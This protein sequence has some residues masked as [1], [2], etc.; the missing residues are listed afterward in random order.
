MR[1]PGTHNKTFFAAK[2]YENGKNTE[3]KLTNSYLW[4][5]TFQRVCPRSPN[6]QNIPFHYLYGYMPIYQ[7]ASL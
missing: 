6:N 4:V 3:T 7:G 2:K 1:A 5:T